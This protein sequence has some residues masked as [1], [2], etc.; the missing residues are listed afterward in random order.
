[1][2]QKS[3]L[4]TI[5]IALILLSSACSSSTAETPPAVVSVE[6]LTPDVIPP[7]LTA[8]VPTLDNLPA[9]LRVYPGDRRFNR[10]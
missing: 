8:P 5:I 2:A 9:G 1:M 6:S 4:V 10:T 3:T 7:T